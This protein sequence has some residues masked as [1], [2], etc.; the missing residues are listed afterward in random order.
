MEYFQSFIELTNERYSASTEVEMTSL[1]AIT[2]R[3]LSGLL[4]STSLCTPT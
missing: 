2:E 3:H 4:E 1:E